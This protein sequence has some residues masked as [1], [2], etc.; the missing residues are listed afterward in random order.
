MHC[1]IEM[2]EPTGITNKIQS[3]VQ[4]QELHILE[5]LNEYMLDYE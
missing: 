1:G 2:V 3:L 4:S 5:F